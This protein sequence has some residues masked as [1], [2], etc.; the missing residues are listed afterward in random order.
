[1]RVRLRVQNFAV[2]RAIDFEIPSGVNVL[3]GA[4]GSGKSTVLDVIELLR[5]AYERGLQESL[6]HHFGGASQI[7]NYDAPPDADIVLG[8]DVGD[9]EWTTTLRITGGSLDA[10]SP[11]TL[12]ARGQVKLRRQALSAEADFGDQKLKVGEYLAVRSAWDRNQD[13]EDLT[14]WRDFLRKY[15]V[16]RSYNYRLH[17]LSKFGSEASPDRSLDVSGLNAFS[18][19]QNWYLQR[20]YRARHSFVCDSL[21]HIYPDYFRDF[22]FQVAGRTVTLQILTSRWGERPIQVSQ[23]STGFMMA[24]LSLCAVAS[25]E[26]GGLVAID[27]LENSIQPA[28][29]ERLFECIDEYSSTNDVRVLIATHS[30]VVLDQLR[31]EPSSIFVLDPGELSPS[32]PLPVPLDK[33]FDPGWLAQFSLGRLYTSL[34]YGAHRLP[35]NV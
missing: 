33:L 9:V 24:F 8:L 27:E 10:A 17:D 18:V 15:R 7:R 30:P 2:L 31:T 19:F 12:V 13:D 34:E 25:G 26:P 5:H 23:E 35:T 3:V 28:A 21:R 29:I 32:Q 20:P 1:V 22:D 6:G 16:Y 4:N 14:T 11:E